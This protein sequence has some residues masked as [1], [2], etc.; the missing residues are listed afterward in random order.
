MSLENI[1]LTKEDIKNFN[2]NAG[3]RRWRKFYSDVM[4]WYLP[5]TIPL[6]AIL[7]VTGLGISALEKFQEVKYAWLL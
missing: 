1:R 4:E 6:L 2:A 5:L 7:T 3:K